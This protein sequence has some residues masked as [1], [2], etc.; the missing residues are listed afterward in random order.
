MVEAKKGISAMQLS[1]HLDVNYKTAWSISHKIRRAMNDKNLALFGGV[2]EMDE[3]Y[4]DTDNDDEDKGQ[5]GRKANKTP[6]IGIAERG[7]NIKAFSSKNIMAGTLLHF[8]RRNIKE[9]AN[10][11]TDSNSSYNNF[12]NWFKHDKV[13]HAVEFVS[14]KGTHTNTVESFWGLLK[15]GIQGQC[16]HIS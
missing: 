13:K 6:V 3:T 14:P 4:I 16:H 8:A 12:K 9:G 10:V 2:V 7:G 1:R 11:N 5:G 15:R